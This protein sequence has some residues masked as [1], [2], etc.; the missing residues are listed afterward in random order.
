MSAPGGCAGL[1]RAALLGA[2]LLL[3]GCAA[4]APVRA[5]EPVPAGP[6]AA[7]LLPPDPSP[8]DTYD[9]W[10][11]F[12]R[13]VYR[14]NARVDEAVF[15]PVAT[16]W[17][18]V[19]PRP[20]RGGISNMFANLAEVGNL[21][22]YA[23]Q[24]RFAYS[25]RSLARL[26]LNTTLGLGGVFDVAAHAGLERAPTSFGTTLARW[27]VG[28]GPYVVVPLLGPSSVRDGFGFLADFGIT[29]GVDF[30]GLY[31]SDDSFLLGVTNAVDTRSR[32]DFRYYASGSPFEYENLRFLYT[33]KRM[34]EA[35]AP[36]APDPA[37]PPEE[38][39]AR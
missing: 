37:Q 10:E 24:G 19:L 22:N 11:R 4:T 8:L 33:R 26:L 35:L 32:L 9:P 14:F 30:G 12:N 3:A 13:G 21:A 39:Q 2:A 28:A 36:H 5:P 38:A 17:K 7:P 1:A 18:T 31:S 16:A 20:V 23:L 25:G 27:G 29:R 34:L 15:L 6:L